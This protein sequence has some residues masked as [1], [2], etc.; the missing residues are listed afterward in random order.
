M[1]DRSHE[2]AG[3]RMEPQAGGLQA[4]PRDEH[5][6]LISDFFRELRAKPQRQAPDGLRPL[7]SL[8]LAFLS[9]LRVCQGLGKVKGD[10]EIVVSAFL[11]KV[12]RLSVRISCI[13][14][15]VFRCSRAA[16][17]R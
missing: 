4:G 13:G 7:P 14:Q 11:V 2:N 17:F 15:F 6:L 16:Q 8:P 9:S 3:C 1:G 5:W 12:C 10:G